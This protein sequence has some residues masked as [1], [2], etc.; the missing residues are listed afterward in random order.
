MMSVN[1]LFSVMS[2]ISAAVTIFT[3]PCSPGAPLSELDKVLTK[4]RGQN[5]SVLY[6]IIIL[7]YTAVLPHYLS[8]YLLSTIH[9]LVIGEPSAG[10]IKTP[11]IA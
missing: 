11:R 8:V 4:V 2:L 10:Y 5:L 7:I 6:I 9:D 1:M 3:V